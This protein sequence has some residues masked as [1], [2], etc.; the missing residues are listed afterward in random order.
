[1]VE[2]GPRLRE[3]WTA[4]VTGEDSAF[5]PAIEL[6]RND[7]ELRDLPRHMLCAM[8]K[9]ANVMKK[10]NSSG[11]RRDVKANIPS[12]FK[13]IAYFD[14]RAFPLESRDA[15]VGQ[16]LPRLTEY[17]DK[18]IPLCELICEVIFH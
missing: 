1:M 12:L 4:L 2:A 6:F 10:L 11:L 15:I 5:I 9:E 17:L 16:G 13:Q 7:H 8:H 18:H 14:N 3:T